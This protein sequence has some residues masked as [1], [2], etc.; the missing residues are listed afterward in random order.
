MKVAIVHDWL[1]GGGAE[2][3]VAGLHKLYPEAPIYTSY[4]TKK[5]RRQLNG[6]VVTGYLQ[7]WPFSALRKYLPLLRGWWFS[8]LDLSAFDLVISSSGAEAKFVKIKPPAVHI[9]YIHA[10]THY[11]WGRYAEYLKRPGFGIF[12]PLA[13]LGL[14]LLVGPRRRKDY[15]AAQQPDYLVANSNYT[16][17]QIKKYY[18]RDSVVIHPPVDVKRFRPK[19]KTIRQG[20]LAAGRQTP[21]KRIDLAVEACAELDLPLKVIGNGPDH[22]KLIRMAG[23]RVSFLTAVPDDEM[24]RHF[25]QA[26]AF[27]FPGIDDFGIVAVEALAAG[28]PVIAYGQGGA[29][30]YVQAGKTGL[31]FEEQSVKSLL[32]AIGKFKTKKFDHSAIARQADQYS[33]EKFR[34]R[35]RSYVKKLNLE[36]VVEQNS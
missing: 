35:W 36:S 21:Y 24:P 33:A 26:E 11:Y 13:R 30:D 27:I 29:L 16:K 25:Q 1:I 15:K 28:T 10:P 32:E 20:F 5:W 23:P 34:S 8:R 22:S 12:D 17:E 14:L 4:S 19:Q 31:L 6:Q 7:H 2:Q 3:V 18:G 9:A